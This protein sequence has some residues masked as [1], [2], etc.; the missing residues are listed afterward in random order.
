MRFAVFTVGLPELTPEEAVATLGELGYDGVEWR[1]VDQQ[2]SPDGRPGFWAGNRCTWPLA[3]FPEDALRVRAMTGGAGL[4]TP[5]V[6][7]YA[8][9]DDPAAVERAMRGAALLGAPALRINVPK[10]DGESAYLP[11]RDRALGQYR[12]VAALA[13]RHGV[14]ALAEIHHG[15]LLPSASAAAA[16]LEAFD[17][18]D[19]GVIHDAGNMV[20]EGHE[21]YR[22]GLETLGPYLAHVHLKNARWVA[23][24]PRP[25][26]G[27]AWRAEW[28]PLSDGLVDLPAL[29]RALRRVG[30][31]GWVSFEDFSTERPLTD[32]LR[33]NLALARRLSAEVSG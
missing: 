22:L 17:P 13:R 14:R 9:C 15:S 2:P 29:F 8:G 33:D 10:Y 21:Q 19:V 6:G 5:V 23:A 25:G 16:F 1:V 18:Q 30:Y 27:T 11:L 32:R 26:G 7:A 31:D 12:E 20:H 24:G 28:A 4:E 3:T